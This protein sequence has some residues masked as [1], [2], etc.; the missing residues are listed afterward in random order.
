MTYVAV[1]VSAANRKDS[2]ACVLFLKNQKLLTE[3]AT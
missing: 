3:T 2:K 1:S